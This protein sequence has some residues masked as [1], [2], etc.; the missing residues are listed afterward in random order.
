MK[1]C[2]IS[3]V[4]LLSRNRSAVMLCRTFYFS[5]MWYLNVLQFISRSFKVIWPS[6]FRIGPLE[7]KI[8]E[9]IWMKRK[10]ISRAVLG[11]IDPIKADFGVKIWLEHHLVALEGV[12]GR[13][14]LSTQESWI[15]Y[16]TKALDMIKPKKL[17]VMI[18][19]TI[20]SAKL[21]FFLIYHW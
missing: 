8:F 21:R 4:S 17:V 7:M 12:C 1:D 5:I 20:N 19:E 9:E 14:L 15:V 6:I 3:D 13:N 2:P 18:F 11:V 10:F 16:Q